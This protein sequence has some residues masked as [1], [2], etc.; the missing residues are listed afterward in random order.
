MLITNILTMCKSHV[1]RFLFFIL[2]VSV[3]ALSV[4]PK[5]Y[6]QKENPFQL[7]GD[8]PV[9]SWV[10]QTDWQNPNLYK[11]DSLIEL[12]KL[13][14]TPQRVRDEDG[15][16]SF[17]EDPYINAYIRWRNQLAPFVQADGSIKYDPDY[18]RKQL[19]KSIEQQQVAA[20]E[21]TAQKTTAPANWTLL[22]PSQTYNAGTGALK[23]YQANIY[24]IAIAPSNPSVLYAGSEPGTFF[25]SADKGLNWVSVSETLTSCGSKS[26]AVDPFNENIVYTYDG[27]AS[28][29]LKTTTGGATWSVLSAYTGGGGNAIAINRNTGRVFI[30]GATAIYYSDNAGTTWTMATGS[31]VT[32]TLYD[33]VLN[34]GGPDT[35]YAVG[36]TAANML[37][38]L[39]SVNGGAS[40]TVVTGAVSTTTTS[41]ARLGVTAAN[42][43]YVYCV[44][45]GASVPPVVIRSINSGETWAITA[46][47]TATGLTGSS[48][49]VGLGMSNGQGFYDLSLVVS[50]FN[51]NHV[52]VG[53]TTTYKSTDGGFNFSPLGGYAGP[54]GLHPDLQQAVALGSDAYLAT[55]GGVNYSSD[56]FTHLS[57]WSVRNNGLRSSEF[58]GFGQGWDEDIVVGGRYHNGNTAIYDLY[59]GGKSLSLGGGEDATG[60]VYHGHRQTAGF[61]DIGNVIVPAALAG[62]VQY[63]A[64]NVPNSIWP[65]DDYYGQF[66]SKLV[67]DPRYSNIFYLGKDSILWK[68][69]NR[70][71]SYTALHNFGSGNKVWRFDVARSNPSVIYLCATNGVYKTTDAGTTWTTL[72]LPATWQNYNSD[73]VVNPL[74]EQEVY[75]C[76]ANGTTANKVFKSLDGGASWTNITGSV[77]N[78]KKVAF[79]QFHG[80]TN[81]G[82][83]AITNARPAKVY[84][85]DNTM[86]DWIDFS[87]GLPASLDARVGALLFYRDSKMRLAGN[88]SVW[89]SPLY[90][91][92]APVAQPMADRQFVGCARDTVNFFDYSMY[93]YAGAT[94]VWS[95]PGALWVSSTSALRPQVVY[96]GP[97]SYNVSLTVTNALAQT[98]TRNI[99][100]MIT[101]SDDNCRPDTTAGKCLQLNGTSQTVNLGVANINSNTFSISCW[102]QPAGKQSSFSQIVGHAAYPGSANYGFGLGFKFNGYTPNL[103]LCYTDSIVNYTNTSNLVCDSTKWNF[104]VLTY[105]PSGVVLYLNGVADTVNNGPMPVIDLSQAPFQT[106][107]DVHNGQGSKYRG[108]I[109]EVKFYNYTLSQS[110][111][112]EKMHLISDPFTETGLIKY[113]Q[114]NQYDLLSGSL[115]DVRSNFNSFVPAA[116]IVTSTA[117][118]ATGRVVRMPMVNSAG[119]NSFSTADVDLHL[120]AGGAYPNGEVVAFHL[121]SGPD[122]RP[123]SRPAVP[124]YFVINNYGPNTTITRPDSTVFSRLNIGYAG[125]NAGDF[126][127]YKRATGDFG[128]TWSTELDSAATL[129]YAVAGSKLTWKSIIGDTVFN[130]QYIIVNND[131]TSYSS[132][133]ISGGVG[134]LVVSDLYPNPAREWTK[135]NIHVPYKKANVITCSVTNILG[136]KLIQFSENVRAGDNT[137]LIRMPSLAVGTYFLE[138]QMEGLPIATRKLVIH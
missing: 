27:S 94:R 88:C 60:H 20:P 33:L 110:E 132:S 32:G 39:R 44:N 24:C 57:N 106:N 101:V 115:Y 35:V 107:L 131:T 105:S 49:T 67:I 54:F 79:L 130:S 134:R 65:Q 91:T 84:Y 41:G 116:N 136:E 100:G 125:Y 90:A 87:T 80:G 81:S 50:P 124:G 102:I 70:G 10:K 122:T 7:P 5:V 51:A 26:I 25:R 73:I 17:Y 1:K 121:L 69:S 127:L 46:S 117:P 34:P 11:I 133:S 8:I 40:F 9:P 47:S 89:E 23:N 4:T 37:V 6:G 13:E 29:L 128:N 55:D 118:V 138:F 38:L 111:V 2:V 62:A 58:W 85:R 126:R 31:T 99:A 71:F 22:G 83:Y 48:A 15:A 135:I 77:L 74:N 18:A 45:I 93:D 76:M 28:A 119:L 103:I 14:A 42:N 114:F 56:F 86:S 68:S 19:I 82:V 12:Y 36:S 3:F 120:P 59:G 108:K 75:F 21:N 52:I 123:D 53:T 92:G 43:S 113:F 95:F 63:S 98:H 72:T 66:S 137:L 61:R 97:G 109:E 112:R 64:P 104:V 30:A 129:I 78:N 96:P 16:L